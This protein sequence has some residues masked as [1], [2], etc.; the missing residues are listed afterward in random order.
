LRLGLNRVKGF[1]EAAAQRI[2]AARK[3]GGPFLDAADLARRAELDRGELGCLAAAGALANLAGHR[4]RA[5]WEVA[6]IERLPPLLAEAS[7]DEAAPVLEAPSEGENIVADYATLGLTLERHPLALLRPGLKHR[8]LLSAREIAQLPHGRI[9]RAAGL[10][11]CRQRPDTE[12]G[13]TFVT[14]EDETGMVNVVVWRDLAQRQ[15]RELLAAQLL[16]VYGKLER[17]GEVIH[18][19]AGRLVDLSPLLGRLETRS[20]D[21]H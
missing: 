15:R 1:N 10:V 6:G 16:G 14:L 4:R 8:R 12:S 2:G 13:V 19:I 9:A 5:A 17:Q 18:L 21:F 20:R 11:T 7:F 3:V